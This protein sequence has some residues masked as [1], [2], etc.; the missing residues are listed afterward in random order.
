[1]EIEVEGGRK[2]AIPEE[3][4]LDSGIRKVVYIDKGQGRFAPRRSSLAANG[5]LLSKS[6]RGVFRRGAHHCQR[7]FSLGFG[8]SPERSDGR[9][10]WNAGNGYGRRAEERTG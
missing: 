1:M 3:A 7:K 6:L 2:L 9:H 5:W 10:G 4:V 8:K